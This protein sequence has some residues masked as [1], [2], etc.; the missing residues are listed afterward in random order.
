[1]SFGFSFVSFYVFMAVVFFFTV[2]VVVQSTRMAPSN[3]CT[4]GR[5]LDWIVGRLNKE[6]QV[7]RGDFTV[8]SVQ[9]QFLADLKAGV[10]HLN[11]LRPRLLEERGR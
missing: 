9:N 4:L 11:G 6:E 8:K 3:E 2:P 10:Y 5:P 7:T 1:M